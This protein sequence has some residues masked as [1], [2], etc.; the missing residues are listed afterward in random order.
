VAVGLFLERAKR[1]SINNTHLNPA[2]HQTCP[3]L[4]CLP[5]KS[6]FPREQPGLL[7]NRPTWFMPTRVDIPSGISIGSAVFARLTVVTNRHTENATPFVAVWR[8][9]AVQLLDYVHRLHVQL[10]LSV[11]TATSGSS[12]ASLVALHWYSARLSSGRSR[13]VN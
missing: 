11:T 6:A 2:L 3:S 10:T 4:T 1:C 9:Y 5:P 8:M 12:V 13:N 7:S